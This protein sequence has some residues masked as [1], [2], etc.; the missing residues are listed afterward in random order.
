MLSVLYY[1]LTDSAD[2]EEKSTVLLSAKFYKNNSN[3]N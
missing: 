3:Y 2:L 1:I